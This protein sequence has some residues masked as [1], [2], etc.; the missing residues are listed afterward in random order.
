MMNLQP[1]SPHEALQLI[2]SLSRF[3]MNELQELVHRFKLYSGMTK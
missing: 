2:P 1:T 3:E